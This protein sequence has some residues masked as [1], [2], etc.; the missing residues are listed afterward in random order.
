MSR[1]ICSASHASLFYVAT[2]DGLVIL[3]SA[4]SF[5]RTMWILSRVAY[6]RNSL[7]FNPIV[8]YSVGYLLPV[9]FVAKYIIYLYCISKRYRLLLSLLISSLSHRHL[10]HTISLFSSLFSLKHYFRF[11]YINFLLANCLSV[12]SQFPVEPNP[13]WNLYISLAD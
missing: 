7:L 13:L 10:N 8:S 2:I 11:Y 6:T 1:N 12:K 9:A 5:C 4:S 3:E